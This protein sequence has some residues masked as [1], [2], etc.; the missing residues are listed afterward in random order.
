MEKSKKKHI[1]IHETQTFWANDGELHI[2]CEQG[3]ITWNL[4]TLYNDIPHI[5]HFCI[6]EHK[7]KKTRILKEINKLIKKK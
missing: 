3:T 5:L 7:K 2:D 4:E 6:E 1:Y